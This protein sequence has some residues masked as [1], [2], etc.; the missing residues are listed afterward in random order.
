MTDAIYRG[1]GSHHPSGGAAAETAHFE[2]AARFAE[3]VI[4]APTLDLAGANQTIKTDIR[5]AIWAHAGDLT[6]NASEVDLT[7]ETGKT[8][9]DAVGKRTWD[10]AE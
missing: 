1:A 10:G 6:H 7:S 9:W 3:R 5:R 4:S 2:G 8:V